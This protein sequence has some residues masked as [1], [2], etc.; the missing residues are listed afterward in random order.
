MNGP[1][2]VAVS[3]LALVVPELILIGTALAL[4][5]AASR[6]R[7][8]PAAAVGT[9]LAALAA[10]LASGWMLSSD[11]ETGFAGM[12]TRDGYSGFFK[13]LIA[14][15]LALV[16]LLSV[17]SREEDEAPRAR[18]CG[19]HWSAAAASYLGGQDEVHGRS[20]GSAR[21]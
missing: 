5:L 8:G 18:T 6:I 13:I 16:A 1:D 19:P 11:T 9:V 4:I 17:K 3:D 20:A 10:A 2:N 21:A 14:V 7:R 12:I 15:S